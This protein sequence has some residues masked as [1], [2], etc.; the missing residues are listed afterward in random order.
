MKKEISSGFGEEID[1]I[2][3]HRPMP[4][5]LSLNEVKDELRDL[6]SLDSDKTARVFDSFFPHGESDL[7]D[8]MSDPFEEDRDEGELADNG[9]SFQSSEFRFVKGLKI[10]FSSAVKSF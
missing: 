10:L 8:E 7:D 6:R 4:P 5:S 3:R 2:R 9:G 1:T